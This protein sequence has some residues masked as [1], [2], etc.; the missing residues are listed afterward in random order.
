[1][2]ISGNGSQTIGA[3]G[4]EYTVYSDT[5]TSVKSFVVDAST[6][7]NGDVLLLKCYIKVASGG[8]SRL[9]Y[10]TYFSHLQAD[11]AKVSVPVLAP[12]GFS[13]SVTQVAGT[14]RTFGWAV[15]SV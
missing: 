2:N 10:Q 9:A 6:M 7:E 15:C 13:C 12:Y 5:T 1:M 4:T 8:S 3:I 14:A 11:P